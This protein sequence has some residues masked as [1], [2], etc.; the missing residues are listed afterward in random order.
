MTDY[1]IYLF[2]CLLACISP[3]QGKEVAVSVGEE[4]PVDLVY[5]LLDTENSRW[6]FFSSACRPFGMVN[7][8]PDTRTGD[9]WGAG[10][11][12]KTDTVRGFSH[13]HAWQLSGIPAMPV[14][15][16]ENRRS[17]LFVD[18]SSPFSHRTEKAEAGYHR[19]FLDRY[20]IEAELTSTKRVGFHRYR[21]LADRQAGI[22]F[23]LNGMWGPCENK[24]GQLEQ[25]DRYTL[26]GRVANAPTVRR[27]K[28]VTVYFCVRLDTPLRSL[29]R[30][31]ASGNYLIV[32]PRGSR[33]VKMKVAVSYTSYENARANL[34][35]ELPGWNFEE[36][37]AASKEEWNGLLGRIRV[38]GNDLTARRRFYTD[39]WHALQGRRTISDANGAYPDYTGKNFR[40]GQLPA[41]ESGKPAF[42]HYNSDAFWGTQFSLD[43]LWGL[44][45]PEI[46]EE[47]VRSLLVYYRDGG[48]VP[49]G[50]SGGNYT[51]VMTGASSTPFIVS[52]IQKGIVKEGAEELYAALKKNHLPGGIM[53]K[54]GYEHTTS[55]GGGLK[56]YLASGYVPY[57]L[58]EKAQAFHLQGAGMTLE[59]AYQDYALAQLAWRLGKP[60][61]C[62]L[63]TRRAGN[64]ARL[65]DAETGWMR[66]RD[67]QGRWL[68]GFD[69]YAYGKGFVESNAAQMT[70]FVPH[71]IPGLA[72]LM[73]GAEKAVQ[74][75]NRQ[76]EESA[77][78]DFTSGTSHAAEVH[79]EYRRIPVNYGNQPSIQTAFVFHKLGRP[80]LSQYWSRRVTEQ[81]FSALSPA[82]GYNG[83]EDQGIMGALAVLM[84]TGLF[85]LDGGV[86]LHPEY[87]IGSP[88]FDRITI[89][90]NP[91][92]YPGGRIVITVKN[93]SESGRILKSASWNGKHLPGFTVL[94]T[95]LIRGG[96]LLLEI[97]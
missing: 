65:F 77:A 26:R 90:L 71:D 1:R 40:I 6:F 93:K 56:Y 85:Q 88:V 35:T 64:Y 17:E 69:P 81:A 55:V 10:Y 39:L 4:R 91:A 3:A 92:Y 66:P 38:E 9:D 51:F 59:Y 62:A 23:R 96:N 8:S 67:V 2:V 58:P 31:P 84:K 87:Q 83:D 37:V 52:A 50:P 46:Y 30:D 82:R 76:F 11:C 89:R 19:L 68:P 34:E 73:G 16:R 53:E 29:Y 15:Y 61:E 60:D 33:E 43:A 47:F 27:P 25:I 48:L 75:L 74:K 32:L 12:Y 44:V 13:I 57:P 24:N 63:F 22:V 54:A 28:E 86:A 80:D 18:C 14:T 49:R 94:H 97:R 21:F 41:D 70:W 72:R 36:T 95:E 5:P 20:R 42:N 79:P 45:Y 7:L 78:L